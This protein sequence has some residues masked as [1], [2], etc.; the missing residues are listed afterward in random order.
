MLT[1][2]GFSSR[3]W[4]IVLSIIQAAQIVHTNEF[5]SP[6]SWS[7]NC[8]LDCQKASIIGKLSRCVFMH[9][10]VLSNSTLFAALLVYCA[11][12]K[13]IH[14]PSGSDLLSGFLCP[15]RVCVSLD[16]DE[17][18]RIAMNTKNRCALELFQNALFARSVAFQWPSGFCRDCTALLVAYDKS[19]FVVFIK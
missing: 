9:E 13:K 16:A 14:E 4:D 15:I 12:F 18:K 5:F 17:I 7:S 19:R 3:F 8:N 2:H 6:Y 11:N 10:E 1:V